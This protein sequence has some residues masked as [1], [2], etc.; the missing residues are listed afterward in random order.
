MVS[1]ITIILKG[2]KQLI[3]FSQIDINFNDKS[4]S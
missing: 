4:V 3:N 2:L 1:L